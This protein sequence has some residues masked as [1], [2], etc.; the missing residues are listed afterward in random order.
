MTYIELINK[1]WKVDNEGRFTPNER[2]VYFTL[3]RKCNELGWKIEFNESNEYLAMLSDMSV[4]SMRRSRLILKERG[5]INFEQGDGRRNM[6][7]YSIVGVK[8]CKSDTLYSE[9]GTVKGNIKGTVKGAKKG[10]TDDYNIRIHKNKEEDEDISPPSTSTFSI[11]DCRHNYDK[12]YVESK[13]AL[14]DSQKIIHKNLIIFQDIFDNELT[15]TGKTEK[16]LSDYIDHFAKWVNIKGVDG[17]LKIVS[18]FY[19]SQQ[20]QEDFTAKYRQ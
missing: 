14:C 11:K 19:K 6:T 5:L 15:S 12:F 9:K 1:F 17:R 7:T 2:S 4:N 16:Q 10:T 20:T 18:D 3:L 13:M 8:G